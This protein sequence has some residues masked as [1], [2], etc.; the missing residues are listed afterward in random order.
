VIVHETYFMSVGTLPPKY[1]SPLIVD[2][3]AV[4]PLQIALQR[5]ET[6]AGRSFEISQI[7][8]AIKVV[9]F[10]VRSPHHVSWES[11]Q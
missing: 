4:E 10:V 9:K 1:D 5:L 2:P 3:N 8:G 7:R 11:L 6:V